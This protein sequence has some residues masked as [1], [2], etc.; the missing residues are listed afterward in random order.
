MIAMIAVI[1]EKKNSAIAAIIA[2]IW[3]AF[4]YAKISGNFGP[5]VNGT[6]RPRWKFSCSK[7][8]TS[9]GGPL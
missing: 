5:N 8:Y 4:H 2:I 3:G 7:W 9:R 6:V 1:A